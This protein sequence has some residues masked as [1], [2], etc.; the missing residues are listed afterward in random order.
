MIDL[1]AAAVLIAIPPLEGLSLYSHNVRVDR[2]GEGWE[3]RSG[4]ILNAIGEGYDLVLF[5]EM[6][7][8]QIPAVY[9]A[10]PGYHA[11]IGERSDGHRGQGFYEYN[12]VFYRADRFTLVAASSFW[13]GQDPSEPGATLPGTKRHGRVVTWTRLRPMAGGPDLLVVNLHTHGEEVEAAMHLIVGQLAPQMIGAAVIFAGDYNAGPDHPA[14]VWLGQQGFSDARTNARQVSGPDRTVIHDG[15]FTY[16]TG[17]VF[18]V[19]T[20]D[21]TLIDHV[22]ACGL[23]QP[24]AFAVDELPLGAEEPN[25]RASDHYAVS[26]RYPSSWRACD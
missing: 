17:R 15:Q 22:F 18:T 8:A 3:R 10:L 23:A 1:I 26:V 20:S 19:E 2:Q 13:V 24:D 6:T 25:A 21:R 9:S 5:Q 4:P 7:E 11:V 14:L 16:D 12:P